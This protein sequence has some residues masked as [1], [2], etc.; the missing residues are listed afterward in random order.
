VS[1]EDPLDGNVDVNEILKDDDFTVLDDVQGRY[2]LA[3]DHHIQVYLENRSMV[4]IDKRETDEDASETEN[5]PV[6]YQS[7][8]K[9]K[10]QENLFKDYVTGKDIQERYAFISWNGE[11]VLSDT[12][13]IEEGE[14]AWISS[15]TTW[16]TRR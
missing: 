8:D 6:P 13:K 14:N 1:V 2:E 16:D 7:S 4:E 12:D 15:D 10:I 3:E 5:L 11:E 9:L